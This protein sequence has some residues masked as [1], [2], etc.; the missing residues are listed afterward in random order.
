[1]NI[2]DV[3]KELKKKKS[4]AKKG[5]EFARYSENHLELEEY[6]KGEIYAYEEALNLLKKLSHM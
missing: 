4:K 6:S 1:M 3:I 5:L 2:Q